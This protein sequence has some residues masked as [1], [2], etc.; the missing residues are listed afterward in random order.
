MFMN[1]VHVQASLV[2]MSEAVHLT[3]MTAAAL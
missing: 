1:I 2:V 3:V